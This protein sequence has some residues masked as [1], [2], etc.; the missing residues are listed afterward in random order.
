MTGT[1]Q[2]REARKGGAE[3]L[4]LDKAYAGSRTS[5]RASPS[6]QLNPGESAEEDPAR[7]LARRKKELDR[8]GAAEGSRGLT[9]KRDNWLSMKI[10]KHPSS[11]HGRWSWEPAQLFSSMY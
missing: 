5:P 2:G 4:K 1:T 10:C 9:P 6:L 8:L 7:D 11:W 3:E